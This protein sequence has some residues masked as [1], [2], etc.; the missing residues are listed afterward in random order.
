MGLFAGTHDLGVALDEPDQGFQLA[1]I[2]LT[3]YNSKATSWLIWTLIPAVLAVLSV[4]KL[5]RKEV[6]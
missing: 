3:N 2:P 1:S 4:F 6:Q 5:K